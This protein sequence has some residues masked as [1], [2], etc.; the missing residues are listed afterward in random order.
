MQSIIDSPFSNLIYSNGLKSPPKAQFLKTSSFFNDH[1]FYRIDG[2]YFG[3]TAKDV[4]QYFNPTQIDSRKG[5][6]RVQRLIGDE[7]IVYDKFVVLKIE[8][9]EIISEV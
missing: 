4:L 7:L 5:A 6:S 9:Q 2:L 3:L 8:A 1:I